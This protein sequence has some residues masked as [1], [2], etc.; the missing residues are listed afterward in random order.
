MTQEYANISCVKTCVDVVED[1]TS[2]GHGKLKL[3]RGRDVGGQ[4]GDHV[5]SL[6]AVG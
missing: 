6:D 2:H 4:N 5:A 3:I 1:G